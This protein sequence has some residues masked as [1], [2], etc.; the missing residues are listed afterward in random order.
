MGRREAAGETAHGL[1]FAES[2]VWRER[3]VLGMPKRCPG[4]P[5]GAVCANAL[6]AKN[7]VVFVLD[8]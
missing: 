8:C 4:G 6:L 3:S 5:A 7:A 2:V 1:S